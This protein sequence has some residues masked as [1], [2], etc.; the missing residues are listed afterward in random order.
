M[1]KLKNIRIKIMIK[2]ILNQLLLMGAFDYH[3]P[4]TKF[5]DLNVYC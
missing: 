1:M 3:V 2:K 4:K 5:R